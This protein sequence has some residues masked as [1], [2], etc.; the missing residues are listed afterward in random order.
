MNITELYKKPADRNFRQVMKVD[1]IEICGLLKNALKIPMFKEILDY[2]K[3]IFPGL[4]KNCPY[5]GVS[6]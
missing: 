3:A 4:V 2:A 6:E 5:K 1:R